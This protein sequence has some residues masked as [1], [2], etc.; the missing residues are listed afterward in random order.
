MRRFEKEEEAAM[1]KKNLLVLFVVAALIFTL[2]ACG[3]N[4]GNADEETG[5]TG[6][7]DAGEPI[8][9]GGLMAMT[10]GWASDGED[11]SN[12]INLA[13]D[14]RNADGGVAGREIQFDII[15]SAS[16]PDSAVNAANKVLRDDSYE[17]VF[18]PHFSSQMLAIADLINETNVLQIS[19]SQS[20]AVPEAVTNEYTTWNRVPDIHAATATAEYLDKELGCKKVG[21]MA[22]NDDFGETAKNRATAYFDA[23]G[24]E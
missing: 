3:G 5:D 11:I 14:Q 18:G 9:I 6:N 23:Q 4:G 10:G 22:V 20:M 24:I 21:I 17:V 7:A 8:K 15:D 12:A 2:S 19:G 13:V 16:T 1:K